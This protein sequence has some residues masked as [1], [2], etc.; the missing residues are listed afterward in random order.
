MLAV[1][2]PQRSAQAPDVPTIAESGFPG[3]A[4]T[5]WWGLMAP[6]GT[7]KPIVDRIAVEIGKAT[8][9]GQIVEKLNSFGVDPVGS[10]PDEFAAMIASDIRLWGDAVKMAGLQAR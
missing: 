8:K 4:T 9:D 5:S 7:P 1:S 2:S 3:F 10:G 6:A